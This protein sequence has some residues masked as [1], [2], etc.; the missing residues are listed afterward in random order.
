[1]QLIKL[2]D[3]KMYVCGFKDFE[4][5][6]RYK[7]PCS[8]IIESKARAISASFDLSIKRGDCLKIQFTNLK[9]PSTFRCFDRI[10]YYG[11]RINLKAALG[12]LKLINEVVSECSS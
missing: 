6:K 7:D 5:T 8:K 4:N 10:E 9:E 12:D 3:I 2:K 11:D 1:M